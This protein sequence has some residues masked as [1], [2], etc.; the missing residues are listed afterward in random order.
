MPPSAQ[1][2]DREGRLIKPDPYNLSAQGGGSGGGK[3]G[4]GVGGGEGPGGTKGK[5]SDQPTQDRS[6][7]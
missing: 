1:E 7:G 2:R 5:G 3:G 6:S 4:G